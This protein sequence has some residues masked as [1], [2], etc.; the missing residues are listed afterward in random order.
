[1]G[2]GGA[3]GYR[4]SDAPGPSAGARIA[5]PA[6]NR[7]IS[8]RCPRIATRTITPTVAWWSV[9]IR[10]EITRSTG[11]RTARWTATHSSTHPADTKTARTTAQLL[12]TTGG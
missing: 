4:T 11:S 2:C 1:E 5:Y 10:G 9:R 12:S 8:T 7:A 6:P 3:G